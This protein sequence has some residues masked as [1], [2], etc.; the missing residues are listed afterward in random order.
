MSSRQEQKAQARAQREQREREQAVA[1][2]RRRRLLQLGSVIAVAAAG[3]LTLAL[4]SQGSQ[5][6][7]NASAGAAVVGAADARAM[8]DGVPQRGTSLGDPKAP[9]V[10]TEFADLQCPFCR[11]YALNVL[12]T[13]IQRYV[14]TGK[15]R[16]E[17]RMRG[18][19]GPDS[20]VAARAAYAAASRDRM[21]NFIDVFYRNQGT[22]NTGYVTSSFLSRI[23][24]AS[25]LPAAPILAARTSSRDEK[26]VQGAE[27]EA[28][29]AGLSSTPSFLVGKHGGSGTPLAISS[30]DASSFTA[31]LDA[32]LRP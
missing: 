3:V 30:L 10:L 21:W 26:S 29:A 15:L 6:E 31:A 9:M 27:R 17:L 22:E 20:D 13:V 23:A 24:T 12:P 1:Q 18:F 32:A 14:R 8:L 2:R 25:G 19:L 5:A 4:I 16:L 7:P 28:V 11:D